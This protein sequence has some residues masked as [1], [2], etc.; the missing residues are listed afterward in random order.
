[1]AK[2]IKLQLVLNESY[3]TKRL[4]VREVEAITVEDMSQ[5]ANFVYNYYIERVK[6]LKEYYVSISSVLCFIDN[7]LKL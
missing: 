2:P 6:A 1:M 4:A 7:N 5:M 3:P